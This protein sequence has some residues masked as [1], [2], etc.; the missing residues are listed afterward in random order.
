MAFRRSDRQRI[1][2]LLAKFD[3]DIRAA[4]MA[5]VDDIRAHVDFAALVRALEAGDVRAAIDA[6]HIEGSA[7]YQLRRAIEAAYIEAGIDAVRALPAVTDWR[8]AVVGIRFDPSYPRAADWT[9]RHGAEMVQVFAED[10]RGAIRD[11]VEESL[12]TGTNP[13]TAAIQIAGPVNRAT[14]QREGGILGLTRQQ[15]GFVQNA[16]KELASGDADQLAHYLTRQARDRRFDAAVKK[17]IASGKPLD[18]ATVNRMV[19]RYSDSLLKY[20]ADVVAR[21]E[22]TQAAN[23][24]RREAMRQTIEAAGLRTDQIVK[25]WRSTHDNRVRDSH[26]QLDGQAVTFDKPFQSPTGSL[27]MFPG[28]TSMG[29]G[30]ADTIQCRC[31]CT[32]RIL[33][34][35]PVLKVETETRTEYSKRADLVL[36]APNQP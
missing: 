25:Q 2:E 36:E 18:A 19:A 35:K 22:S 33:R 23:T 1:E 16:R 4:F 5:V 30:A 34:D 6:C 3:A 13:R 7:Y 27:M 28:D 8:G 24:A 10:Q 20:R 9:A 31:V 14:G 21:T 32:Y 15:T 17:A 12:R 11:V 26:R 29:A